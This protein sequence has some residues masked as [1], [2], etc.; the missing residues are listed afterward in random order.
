MCV[1]IIIINVNIGS[2]DYLSERS[3]LLFN[4]SQDRD[5]ITIVLKED[6]ISESVEELQAVLSAE[7]ELVRFSQMSAKVFI[8]DND[9]KES[10]K[11]TTNNY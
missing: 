7:E 8:Q 11:N 3:V 1:L 10:T 6:D 2:E 9:S 5:C 4:S